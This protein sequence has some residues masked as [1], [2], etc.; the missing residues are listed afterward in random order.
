M[1]LPLTSFQIRSPMTPVTT[2]PG[3]AYPKSWSRLIPSGSRLR[4]TVERL[5]TPLL[6]GS[7]V[8]SSP[9]KHPPDRSFRPQRRPYT[10][11]GSNSAKVVV[12]F[13]S[14]VVVAMRS[15]AVVQLQN[16]AFDAV[17]SDPEYRLRRH[18]ANRVTNQTITGLV[19]VCVAKSAVRLSDYPASAKQRGRPGCCRWCCHWGCLF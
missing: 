5:G 13:S 8:G 7:L 1:P 4:S 16:N 17:S 14:V 12:A 3:G 9:S 2:S 15:P 11:S 6:S 19:S 10:P 18:P